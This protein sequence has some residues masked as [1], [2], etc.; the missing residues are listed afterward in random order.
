[1]KPEEASG[2]HE[3]QREEQDAR[4]APTVGR[5]ARGVAERDR[6]RADEP[7]DDE[8]ELVVL[9]VRVELGTHEQREE[10]GEGQRRGHDADREQGVRAGPPVGLAGSGGKGDRRRGHSVHYA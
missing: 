9:D 6:D 2:R 10:T 1:V 8:M 5:F 4:V 3:R 7:E